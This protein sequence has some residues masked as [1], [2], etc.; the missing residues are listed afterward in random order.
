MPDESLKQLIQSFAAFS[1]TELDFI[2]SKFVPDSY[3]AKTFLLQENSVCSNL[4][5][6]VDGLVRAYYM[7][8]GREITTYLA[9][10]GDFISAYSSFVTRTKSAESIQCIE[11]TKTVSI[12]YSDM[13]ELYGQIPNWQI[14]GR[15]LAEQNYICMA[16]R[17]LKLQAIPAKEKYLD[18]LS[19]SS[20]KIVQRT[21]LIYIAT[22]LGITAESLSRI[23]KS[24]S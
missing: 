7:R 3:P 17:V 18:F 5:F 9:A 6:V 1:D 23:R 24:I 11:S 13:Q 22:F 16:D 4:H 8:D 14:I 2:L 10:D 12:S 21:P 15:V 19:K 20:S